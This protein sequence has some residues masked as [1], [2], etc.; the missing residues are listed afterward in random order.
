MITVEKI[1]LKR[2]SPPNIL[3][4]IGFCFSGDTTKKKQKKNSKNINLD[5]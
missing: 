5:R 3:I 2:G 4:F 1:M